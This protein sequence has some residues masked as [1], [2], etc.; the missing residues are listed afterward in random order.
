[1]NPEALTIADGVLLIEL[2]RRK[3]SDNNRLFNSDTWT[4]RKIDKVLWTYGR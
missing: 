3:A 4:P 1:M 2:F